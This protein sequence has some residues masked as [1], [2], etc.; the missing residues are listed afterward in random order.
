M[1]YI[2]ESIITKLRK[3]Y[4]LPRNLRVGNKLPVLFLKKRSW[5]GDL[6]PAHK[7]FI[8]RP[9]KDRHSSIII[10]THLTNL[11]LCFYSLTSY[12]K[13]S[14]FSVLVMAVSSNWNIIISVFATLS[15]IVCPLLL[16]YS[17]H[18]KVFFFLFISFSGLL[19]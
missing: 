15:E 1:T 11:F 18:V 9:A 8:E 2:K 7:I 16:G 10:P 17:G 5:T 14:F 6:S 12:L 3:L 19:S 13:S 4:S